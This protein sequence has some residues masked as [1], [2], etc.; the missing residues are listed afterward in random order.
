MQQFI[1]NI[2]ENEKVFILERNDEEVA[3][4]PSVLFT[5]EFSEAIPVICF[6]SDEELAYKVGN[7]NWKEYKIYSLCI[8]S[9]IEDYLVNIYNESLIVGLDYNEEFEGVEADPLDVITLL[10]QSLKNH[11]ID[12]EFEYFKNLNDL[13]NQ[14]TKLLK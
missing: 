4:I 10:A 7:K 3:S 12:L 14:T 6:W 9:F 5:N 11:T 2:I 8:A 1:K 13:Q